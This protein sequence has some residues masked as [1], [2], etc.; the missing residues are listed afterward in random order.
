MPILV[1][2][3]Y[4]TLKHLTNGKT[5]SMIFQAKQ[6]NAMAREIAH[7]FWW[8]LPR[9]PIGVYQLNTKTQNIE[10]IKKSH[11][12]CNCSKAQPENEGASETE[13][14]TDNPIIC[15]SCNRIKNKAL[16]TSTTS[17]CCGCTAK[18]KRRTNYNSN[19]APFAMLYVH[20]IC[21]SCELLMLA[22]INEARKRWEERLK[23][24]RERK[25]KN[26]QIYNNF[27]MKTRQCFNL[28]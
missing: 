13:T 6:D 4:D 8:K 1:T 12:F 24:A 28:V 5:K 3:V 11:Q 20:E 16:R 22:H 14:S 17:V 7:T 27:P 25:L 23:L 26:Y 21:P 19:Q 9:E 2:T 10:V 18:W 15:L